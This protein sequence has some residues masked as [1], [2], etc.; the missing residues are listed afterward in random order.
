M[1]TYIY[2]IMYTCTYVLTPFYQLILNKIGTSLLHYILLPDFQAHVLYMS[3]NLL[4]T[5]S[6]IYMLHYMLSNCLKTYSCM[7]TF[8]LLT[9]TACTCTCTCT[10]NTTL[11]LKYSYKE[12]FIS[13]IVMFWVLKILEV[14]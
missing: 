2:V 14:M 6:Y 12:Q 8:D 13:I 7:T 5:N 3:K 1:Q 9:L 10:A 4:Q 11:N